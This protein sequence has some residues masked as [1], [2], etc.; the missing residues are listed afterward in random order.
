MVECRELRYGLGPGEMCVCP[1]A[2]PVWVGV[3]EV[4]TPVGVAH[5]AQH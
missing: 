5:H 2:V 3:C 4:N 1:P